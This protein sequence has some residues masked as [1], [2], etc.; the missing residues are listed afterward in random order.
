MIL[1]HASYNQFEVGQTY[2]ADS[3]T[4]YFLEKQAQGMDW[5]DLLLNKYKPVSAPPRQRTFFACDSVENCFAFISNRP[6][7]G[8]TPIYYKVEMEN[9]AKGVMCIT[10][11]FRKVDRD[12]PNIPV[13]AQ[14]YWTPTQEWRYF[15]YMSASMKILEIVDEPEF[16]LKIRGKENYTSDRDLRIRMFGH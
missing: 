10:D 12:D 1:F 6:R 3:D 9:P 14:E 11:I 5:V 15:E 13:Y 2:L 4:P 16:I 8:E 7:V